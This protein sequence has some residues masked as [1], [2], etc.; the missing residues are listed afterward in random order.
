[1]SGSRGLAG[2][3][4]WRVHDGRLPIVRPLL[5]VRRRDLR[6]IVAAAGVP[7]VED[8]TNRDLRRTRAAIRHRVLPGLHE[9]ARVENAVLA[10]ARGARASAVR[11]EQGARAVLAEHLLAASPARV[12]L[13]LPI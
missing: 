9:R 1:G 5:A 8:P 2:I 11:A 6:A 7:I 4:E 3:P 13:R 12:E 10:A